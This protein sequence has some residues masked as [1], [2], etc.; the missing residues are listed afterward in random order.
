MRVLNAVLLLSAVGLIAADAPKK[1]D[2]EAFRGNWSVASMAMGGQSAPESLVKN[3]RCRFE[4]KT[5][6]LSRNSESS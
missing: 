5:Y 6:R 3:L 2:S 4:E 1:G